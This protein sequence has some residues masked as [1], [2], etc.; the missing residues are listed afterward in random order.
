MSPQCE[1]RACLSVTA[2]QNY[3]FTI[4]EGATGEDGRVSVNYDGFIADVSVG[5]IM[6]VDGGL[7]T[8]KI[9]S[10][11][12]RDVLM[13]VVDGGKLTSRCDPPTAWAAEKAEASSLDPPVHPPL[14]PGAPPQ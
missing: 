3:T 12:S 8:L 4:D 10:K 7:S 13:E 6:L 14:K 2:G 11:T 9:L 5:D 1:L